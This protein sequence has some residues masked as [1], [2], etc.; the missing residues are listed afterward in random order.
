L[1]YDLACFSPS[2]RTSFLV[3][4]TNRDN[5]YQQEQA[6]AAE[7]AARKL[8]VS[9]E[10]VDAQDDA[11]LQSQQLIHAIQSSAEARPH[12]IVLE[13]VGTGMP[14]VARAAAA[15]GIGWAVLN[16]EVDYVPELRRAHRTPLFMITSDHEEIG[17]LQGRQAAQ[18]VPAGATILLIEGPSGSDAAQKRTAGFHATRPPS[19]R[20]RTIRAQWTEG[21]ACQAVQSWLRLPTSRTTNIGLVAAQDDSMA[22]GARRAF[23]ELQDV[24]AG[25]RWL[26]LPYLGCDGLP[27]TGQAWV[28]SGLLAAAVVVPTNTDLAL[29]MMV[30]ALRGGAIPPECTQTTPVSY[31]SLEQLVARAKKS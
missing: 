3:S 25:Q 27:R 22:I 12:A 5:D 11:V 26:E 4:L 17:R 6:K 14:Q 15:A 8:G 19:A 20:V 31:P 1:R 28:R 13:P 7:N 9:L 24:V 29:D 23:E 30:K 10:I 21:S 2:C 18:L 16:R